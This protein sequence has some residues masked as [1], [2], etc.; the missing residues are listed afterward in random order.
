MTTPQQPVY[1]AAAP[2][3]DVR[4]VEQPTRIVSS[5]GTARKRSAA[6]GFLV[7]GRGVEESA[8]RYAER[9]G[10][11]EQSLIEQSASAMFYID[12]HISCDTELQSEGFLG[13]PA[14]D[15]QAA[16]S[17]PDGAAVSCPC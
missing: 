2:P 1:R 16:D 8:G 3:G 9:L 17:L 15:T 11:V 4:Y 12:Q 14:S 10:D 13:H 6:E 5:A 7:L